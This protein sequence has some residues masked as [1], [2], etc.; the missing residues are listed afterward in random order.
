MNETVFSRFY[1]IVVAPRAA[2]EAVRAE[3]RWTAAALAIVLMVAVLAA[4]TVPIAGPEQLD[5]MQETSLGRHLP[6]EEIE[7]A[8]AQFED[9]GLKDRLMSGL[10]AGFSVLVSLLIMSLVYLLF[11][12]LAG[13]R[14]TYQQIL[15]VLFWANV[16]GI[17]LG[18]L[19]KLPLVLATGSSLRVSLGPALLMADRG[20]LD[21]MFQLLSFFDV[22]S[23]WAVALVVLGHE[24]VH[25]F[26]RSKA[27]AVAGGAWLLMVSVMFGVARLVS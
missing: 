14:A 15:G 12:R 7:Q 11:G 23:L 26:A 5:M 13:G 20:P 6:P 3:P 8:Y 18:S 19:V 4:A 22:F 25:G 24:A 17:G 10:Q 2:M 27:A 1:A 21:P 16:V 9:M